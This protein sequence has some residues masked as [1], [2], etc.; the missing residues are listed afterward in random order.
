MTRQFRPSHQKHSI[1]GMS[2]MTIMLLPF[3]I[4]FVALLAF[5]I[6][7]FVQTSDQDSK[8]EDAYSVNVLERDG[9]IF[10]ESKLTIEK[11]GQRLRCA[12]PSSGQVEDKEPLNCDEP[13]PVKKI[14]ANS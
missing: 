6:F 8:I 10:G 2:S 9:M 11:D 3:Y 12:I 7:N 4:L 14:E 1:K 5:G 13:T